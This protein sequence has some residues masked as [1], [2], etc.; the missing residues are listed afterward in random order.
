MSSI[1]NIAF[2]GEVS[3]R[4]FV[5]APFSMLVITQFADQVKFKDT[6]LLING[7]YKLLQNCL[8]ISMEQQFQLFFKPDLSAL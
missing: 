6:S 3:L 1:L 4:V 8:N 2:V 7:M 5:I